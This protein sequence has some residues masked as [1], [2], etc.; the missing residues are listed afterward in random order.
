[1][2]AGTK[3]SITQVIG[4]TFDA[5][6]PEGDLPDIYNAIMTEWQHDGKASPTTSWWRPCSCGGARFN[7]RYDTRDD[8]G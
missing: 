4:S 3:G 5:Q 7:R 1:M 8:L 6:F 2:A